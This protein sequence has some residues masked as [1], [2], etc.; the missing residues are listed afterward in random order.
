MPYKVEEA[1]TRLRSGW[2]RMSDPARAQQITSILAAGV[3]G[4]ALA[5]HVGVSESLIR[6]LK[7]LAMAQSIEHWCVERGA[8]STREAVRR[9]ERRGTTLQSYTRPKHPLSLQ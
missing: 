4:R 1:I 3:S 7:K 8:I 2:Q 6:H 9:V 5:R